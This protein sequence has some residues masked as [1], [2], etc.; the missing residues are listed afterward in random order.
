M[1][2]ESEWTGLGPEWDPCNPDHDVGQFARDVD[3]QYPFACP[4]SFHGEFR[5]GHF[6][7]C[8][9]TPPREPMGS[10]WDALYASFKYV[11]ERPKDIQ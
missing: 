9:R 7:I 5:P 2:P 8:V 11:S 1:T 3:D 4:P 6:G 10:E